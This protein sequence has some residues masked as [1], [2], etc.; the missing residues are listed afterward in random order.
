MVQTPFVAADRMSSLSVI[1]VGWL[2]QL[3]GKVAAVAS[4]DEPARRT[5][6]QMRT[7]SALL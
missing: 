2:T 1:P 7:R 4:N 3:A 5:D 6:V